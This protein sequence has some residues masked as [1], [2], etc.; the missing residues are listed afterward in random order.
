MRG[1]RS[2]DMLP[3]KNVLDFNALKCHSLGFRFFRTGYWPG[4]KVKVNL[5]SF[6]KGYPLFKSLTVLRKTVET[7]LDLR[8]LME[9]TGREH[10]SVLNFLRTNTPIA[11]A[12]VF[13]ARFS[14]LAIYF[15][16]SNCMRVQ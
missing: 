14:H 16:L 7:G 1:A 6:F 15:K 2:G 10:N 13:E 12:D 9:K 4:F 8:L 11:Y 5:L 3:R